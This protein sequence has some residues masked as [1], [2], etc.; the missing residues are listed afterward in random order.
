VSTNDMPANILS[1]A[2]FHGLVYIGNLF[3]KPY[4]NEPGRT[5]D[6]LIEQ[7]NQLK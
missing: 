3:V 2:H 1:Y 4:S 7:I 6:Q 5:L